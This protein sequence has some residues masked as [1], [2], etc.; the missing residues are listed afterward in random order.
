MYQR[1]RLRLC[2]TWSLQSVI[3]R[4]RKHGQ[5]W[6]CP[7][8]CSLSGSGP[9]I[10][11][12]PSPISSKRNR[13]SQKLRERGKPTASSPRRQSEPPGPHQEDGSPARGPETRVAALPQGSSKHPA[14]CQCLQLALPIL[15]TQ[16][17]LGAGTKDPALTRTLLCTSTP[18][19]GSSLPRGLFR[20]SKFDHVCF[21]S[22]PLM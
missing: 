1:K 16:Q 7:Q 4:V 11:S 14:A 22:Q 13:N 21:L 9:R 18:L 6:R 8:T 2:D 3:H 17:P 15:F 12:L 5:G 10:H 19:A 20:Q